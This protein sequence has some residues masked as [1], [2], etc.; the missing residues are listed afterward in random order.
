[1]LSKLYKLR[2][3]SFYKVV[4][5]LLIFTLVRPVSW[6]PLAHAQSVLDLPPAGAMITPSPEYHPILLKGLK[7][8]PDKPF[9]FDFIV[10]SGDSK[11]DIEAIKNESTKLIKYFLAALTVPQDDL[12]VNLSPYE[13]ERII[14]EAFGQTEMGRDL[15]AQDYILKQLSASLIYP[16]NELGKKFWEKELQV[17]LYL[18]VKIQRISFL[19]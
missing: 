6:S 5:F 13:K 17:I 3:K 7:V 10:E 18:W 19:E 2:N 8:Y 14:P 15:L 9:Q 12:W 4:I 11:Q 1:M 16:E